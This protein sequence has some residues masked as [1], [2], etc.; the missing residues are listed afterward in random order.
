[1]LENFL[2]IL[3][4]IISL[5]YFIYKKKNYYFINHC[6]SQNNKIDKMDHTKN[7]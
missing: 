3:K 6:E 1:M 4:F 2:N 5:F 7:S